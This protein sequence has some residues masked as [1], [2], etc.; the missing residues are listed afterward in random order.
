MIAHKAD[1]D[2][3]DDRCVFYFLHDLVRWVLIEQYDSDSAAIK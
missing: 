3:F 2:N 1:V